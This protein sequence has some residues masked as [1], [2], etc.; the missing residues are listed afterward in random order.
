MM[1]SPSFAIA[2]TLLLPAHVALAYDAP[3]NDGFVTD[4]IG[5]L[6]PSDEASLEQELQSYARE[7]SN[8][9][10][11]LIVGDLHGE[12]IRQVGVEVMREWGIGDERKN[13]GILILFK[14]SETLGD[15]EMYV[16]T[17]YG[18]EGA[19]PDV[20]AKGVIDRDIVPRFREGEYAQ[21]F[22]DGIAALR[23]HIGGEY[24]ADR[25]ESAESGW[26]P[27]L[28]FL[29]FV[30]VDA[31]AAFMGRTK[32]WWFGGMLGC[33]FGIVLT[34]T[35]G[36]WISIPALVAIGLALDY[37]LS[38]AGYGSKRRYGSGRG[39]GWHGG[40]GGFGGGSG[41]F[42]GFGGGSTGGGGAVSRW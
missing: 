25:Y 13:N 34:V 19:V 40:T 38:R 28:L 41:G 10:A 6:S 4:A 16:V 22:R 29:L 32:S 12:D 1:R 33:A 42:G 36:W 11:I 8:E 17:G 2:L 20:V 26:E 27:F 9:V 15:R 14:Q 35:Y 24:S 3:P 31:A 30:F 23:K 37:V 7:T 5:L 39:G 18:L 21:G